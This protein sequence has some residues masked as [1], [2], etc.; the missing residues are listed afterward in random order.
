MGKMG[1]IEKL[2][3]KALFYHLILSQYKMPTIFFII[4]FES[5][6]K[7]KELKSYDENARLA[8]RSKLPALVDR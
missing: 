4:L 6:S 5:A 8:N 1:K 7:R 3:G 2:D